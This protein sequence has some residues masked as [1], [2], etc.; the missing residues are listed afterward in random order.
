MPSR[1]NVSKTTE[2]N[3]LSIEIPPKPELLVKIHNETKRTNI[4]FN[5]I[6]GLISQDV[7]ISAAVLKIVNSSF[8]GLK[9]KIVSIPHAISLF[10]LEPTINLVAGFIIKQELEKNTVMLPRFWDEASCVAE[11]SAYFATQLNITDTNI[12][13]TL[14]L[15]HDVGIPIMAQKYPNYLEV[16][17]QANQ[18][19]SEDIFTD[20]EDKNYDINHSIVG[21]LLCTEWG[22]NESLREVILNHHDIESVFY[23]DT[24]DN[25]NES[26]MLS[27]L[28]IA[29]LATDTI[30]TGTPSHEWEVHGDIIKDLMNITSSDILELIE[31]SGIK[32]PN[33]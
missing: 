25:K 5:K 19:T 1:L 14:G 33:F 22:L 28:K 20:F 16:L 10:G 32:L 13:Y 9:Q 27:I 6:A 23:F 17:K 18:S 15:F 11:F 12:Q 7:A 2:F 29:E 30:R 21:S 8:Y 3:A 24:S 26:K 4:D 31:D